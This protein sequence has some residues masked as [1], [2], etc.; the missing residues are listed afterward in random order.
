MRTAGETSLLLLSTKRHSKGD[1]SPPAAHE[2]IKAWAPLCCVAMHMAVAIPHH[3]TIFFT[4]HSMLK[5]PCPL[6][7]DPAAGLWQGSTLTQEGMQWSSSL[8]AMHGA[9]LHHCHTFAMIEHLTMSPN[10]SCA[11]PQVECN[12][13]LAQE[14]IRTRFSV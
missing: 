6:Q 8:Y 4:Q 9:L 7:Q 14:G 11:S 1:C 5:Q 3:C 10:R 2:C 12:S 13:T